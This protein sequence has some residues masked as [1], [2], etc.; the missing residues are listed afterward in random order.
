MKL[1]RRLTLSTI[2]L[3]CGIFCELGVAYSAW[4]NLTPGTSPFIDNIIIDSG[5]LL[6]GIPGITFKSVNKIK[7]GTYFY[8]D[9][10][11]NQSVDNIDLTYTFEIDPNNL[12]DSFKTPN[13][14][15]GYSFS[16]NVNLTLEGVSDLNK[17]VTYNNEHKTSFLMDVNTSS[18]INKE[19]L[20]ITFNL[21]NSLLL[22]DSTLE[23]VKSNAFILTL[24]KE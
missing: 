23:K 21:S 6:T 5:D 1:R 13:T 18:L 24:K 4:I 12:T 20:N 10:T 19:D 14:Q 11:K 9:E 15:G 3:I 7:V 8:F 22:D 16:L 2:F 17:H